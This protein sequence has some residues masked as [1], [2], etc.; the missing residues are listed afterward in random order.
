MAIIAQS[1]CTVVNETLAKKPSEWAQN[2]INLMNSIPTTELQAIGVKDRT[3][4]IIWVRRII[5]KHNLLKSV[6]TKATQMEQS[7][8]EFKDLFEQ[9]FIK[10]L[11][12]F[13]DE[14][15]KL[16]DQEGYN[17]LLA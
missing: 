6:Q 2:T 3:T 15:G 1:R 10:C 8:H 9:L 13:W 16:Y 11:P 12:P 17:S 5:S 7:I 4:L 14:K